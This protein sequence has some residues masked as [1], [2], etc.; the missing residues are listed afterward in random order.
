[1][2]LDVTITS[3]DPLIGS[4]EGDVMCSP[5]ESD[6]PRFRAAVSGTFDDT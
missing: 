3:T 4:F 2:V 6:T 5:L 1:L